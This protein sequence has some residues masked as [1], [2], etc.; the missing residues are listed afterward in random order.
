MGNGKIIRTPLS[1]TPLEEEKEIE[2]E[3]VAVIVKEG[4]VEEGVVIQ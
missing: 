2:K 4:R 1:L 3:K